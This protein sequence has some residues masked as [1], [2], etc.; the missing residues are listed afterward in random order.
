MGLPGQGGKHRSGGKGFHERWKRRLMNPLE[1]GVAVNSL[2]EK[3]VDA[4]GKG[5]TQRRKTNDTREGRG[6]LSYQK[7]STD[8]RG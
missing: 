5:F 1:G 4:L 3:R 8:A 7:A 6:R 2:G